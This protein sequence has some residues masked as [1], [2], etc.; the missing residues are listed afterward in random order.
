MWRDIKL[1]VKLAAAMRIKLHVL[2]QLFNG[3]YLHFSTASTDRYEH[4]V[5]NEDGVKNN[6][7]LT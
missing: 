7:M 2:C 1:N 6:H 4:L 3:R 5:L